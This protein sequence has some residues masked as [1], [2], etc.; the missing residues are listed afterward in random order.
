MTTWTGDALFELEAE[1]TYIPPPPPQCDQCPAQAVA[2]V[3]AF[4]AYKP[5]RAFVGIGSKPPYAC[6]EHLE[7]ATVVEREKVDASEGYLI[8]WNHAHHTAPDLP[9]S[10]FAW[11]EYERVDP[12]WPL[13]KAER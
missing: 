11:L 7:Q 1:P 13:K 6:V 3:Y 2:K 12:P 10:D 5:R 8:V 9:G 4:T